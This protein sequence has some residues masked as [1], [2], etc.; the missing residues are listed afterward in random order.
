MSDEEINHNETLSLR[1]NHDEHQHLGFSLYHVSSRSDVHL[2][3][4]KY[5][6]FYYYYNYHYIL[7]NKVHYRPEAD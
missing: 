6:H 2:T 4:C 5:Y 7:T 3:K 1:F